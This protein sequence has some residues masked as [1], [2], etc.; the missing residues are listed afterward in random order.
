MNI[1]QEARN[2]ESATSYV[3]KGRICLLKVYS[4]L[5]EVLGGSNLNCSFLSFLQDNIVMIWF[6]SPRS[7]GQVFIGTCA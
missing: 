4:I 5:Q 6:D 1:S 7:S 2:Y 3:E